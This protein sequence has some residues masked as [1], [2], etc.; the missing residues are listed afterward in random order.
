[1]PYLR[2]GSQGEPLPYSLQEAQFVGQ[3]KFGNR[4]SRR[5]HTAPELLPALA[6]LV[7][8]GVCSMRLSSWL[9]V[10]E[11][12]ASSDLTLDLPVYAAPKCC[13]LSLRT[14]N[15]LYPTDGQDGKCPVPPLRPCR[16]AT[17]RVRFP[18]QVVWRAGYHVDLIQTY[19]PAQ[20]TGETTSVQPNRHGVQPNRHDDMTTPDRNQATTL[21]LIVGC[22]SGPFRRLI[23][24]IWARAH[25]VGAM[26]ACMRHPT[27]CVNHLGLREFCRCGSM[28]Q[29][30]ACCTGETCKT[31]QCPPS[32]R[33]WWRRP[34]TPST[35]FK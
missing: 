33:C 9:V 16:T 24:I 25:C 35:C 17:L 29:Y 27:L 10:V 7:T 5:R 4:T 23:L 15:L 21:L 34:S 20:K 30:A 19:A 13:S 28:R 14:G 2:A 32:G 8:P 22:L 12:L 6:L 1:M 31:S 18:G 11:G 26:E 3:W